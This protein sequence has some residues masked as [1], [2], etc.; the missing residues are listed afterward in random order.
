MKKKFSALICAILALTC[1]LSACSGKTQETQARVYKDGMFS[2]VSADSPYRDY[3]AA[4]Y[5]LGLMDGKDDGTFG[6]GDN[7]T[8]GQ[9]VAFADKLHSIYSGDKA[10]FESTDPWY[11]AYADYAV[12][13][14]I[15]DSEITD[16]TSNITRA[17]FADLLAHSMPASSLPAINTVEDNAIPD[18]TIDDEYADSIYLLYRAG[19]FTGNEDDGSFSPTGNVTRAEVA[20]ALARMEASSMRGKVTL[21]APEKFSPDLQ[22]Q[23]AVNDDYFKDAAIVGNSLT[24]GL[25]MYAKLS[26]ITYYSGTSMSVTTAMQKEIPSLVSK[27]YAKIYI[28]L[29]INELGSDASAFKESYGK[30]IDTIKAAEPDADIYIVSIFPVSKEKSGEGQFTIDRVKNFNAK[31]YELAGEKECYYLD[32]YSALVGSDGYL[33]ADNTWDGV[34]LTPSTYSVWENYMRTHYASVSTAADTTK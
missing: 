9:A 21:T 13:N 31:L 17:G 33:P 29:G 14:G 10:T 8:V 11:K 3:I 19:I 18:V 25:K 15:I 26:T 7:I 23:A 4:A 24:E 30:M 32:V 5:E 22:E 16:F 6:A 27:K 28:A 1:L 2:D 20:V 12:A 34:H